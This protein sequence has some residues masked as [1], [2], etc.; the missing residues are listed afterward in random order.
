MN[1]RPRRPS[2]YKEGGDE[3]PARKQLAGTPSLAPEIDLLRSRILA[4]AGAT[5]PAPAPENDRLLVR[6]L[7]VLG[8]L[9]RTQALLAGE[10]PEGDLAELNELVRKRLQKAASLPRPQGQGRGEG[11][12]E[13]TQVL[14]R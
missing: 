12:S 5:E 6:M 7:A 2:S 9:V 8:Q 10:A 13:V 4:L 11:A 3:T 1:R 14:S